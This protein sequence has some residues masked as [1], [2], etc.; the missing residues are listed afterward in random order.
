MK[1][2]QQLAIMT[3]RRERKAASKKSESRR[4]DRLPDGTVMDDWYEQQLM[5]I[6]NEPT[7]RSTSEERSTDS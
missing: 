7:K 2:R 3:Q 6:K 4:V 5:E 1:R